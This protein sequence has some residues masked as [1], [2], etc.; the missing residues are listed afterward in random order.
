[1]LLAKE[2]SARYRTRERA[3]QQ[4]LLPEQSICFGHGS[5]S[6]GSNYHG[7]YAAGGEVSAQR[8]S[9]VHKHIQHAQAHSLAEQRADAKTA[10][11]T[12]HVVESLGITSSAEHWQ[13]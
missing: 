13:G 10:G 5:C 4:Q 1:V 6:L 3:V 7:L 8:S 2:T 11:S 12:A 9:Q